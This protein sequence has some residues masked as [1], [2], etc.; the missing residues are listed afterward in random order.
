M[1]ANQPFTSR[2]VIVGFVGLDCWPF[3]RYSILSLN[4]TSQ[5]ICMTLYFETD[6]HW[7]PTISSPTFLGIITR[8][9][10]TLT[11][12]SADSV[13]RMVLV[14]LSRWR[15]IF[16]KNVHSSTMGIELELLFQVLCEVKLHAESCVEKA[17]GFETAKR[18]RDLSEV[19]AS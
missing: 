9:N 5:L 3:K 12:R 14:P 2:G 18:K 10:E 8:P 13:W 11:V 17:R 16:D 7:S 4:V 6:R 19:S 15:M 1:I